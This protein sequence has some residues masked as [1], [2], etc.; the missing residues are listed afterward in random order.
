[1]PPKPATGLHP[2]H[3]PSVLHK[4]VERVADDGETIIVSV[5]TGGKPMTWKEANSYKQRF[6]KFRQ[7][8]RAAVSRGESQWES[9][10]VKAELVACSTEQ[11]PRGLGAVSFFNREK[12]SFAR[13]ME[14]ALAS[15]EVL[16]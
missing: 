3:F 2:G 16:D 8:L 1:M 10:L 5:V 11:K 15:Q 4:L 9:K 13:T 14:D 6:L 7:A 12:T